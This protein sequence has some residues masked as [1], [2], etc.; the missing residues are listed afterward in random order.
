MIPHSHPVDRDG[1]VD[2]LGPS[3]FSITPLRLGSVRELSTLVQE[4]VPSTNMRALWMLG[5]M[6]EAKNSTT[7][8]LSSSGCKASNGSGRHIPG[9]GGLRQYVPVKDQG[10]F[11]E[12][13][14]TPGRG[15]PER[16][17]SDLST[18]S[19]GLF[20]SRMKYC[21]QIRQTVRNPECSRLGNCE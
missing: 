13:P 9:I 8:G 11:A 21:F 2:R 7:R 15:A 18:L 10:D 1:T 16:L 19:I 6:P 3:M 17:L 5:P 14:C 12:A 4:T 20:S